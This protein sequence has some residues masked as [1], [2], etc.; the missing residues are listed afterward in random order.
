M[1]MEVITRVMNSH[2]TWR[3]GKD[4]PLRVSGPE[5]SPSILTPHHHPATSAYM[6]T[7]TPLSSLQPPLN[8]VFIT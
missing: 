1:L 7:S 4:T 2:Q 3:P 8:V 5:S 6:I